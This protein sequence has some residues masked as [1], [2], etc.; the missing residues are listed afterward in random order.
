MADVTASI[1]HRLTRPEVRKRIDDFVA[2]FHQHYAN[3]GR[4][5]SRWS[6]DT[7]TFTLTAMAMTLPG[8]LDV[9]DQAVNLVVTLP[10]A[11]A[12]LAGGLK[13]QIEREGRKL[14]GSS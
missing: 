13:P 11:L 4:L 9:E 10:W 2:Q 5:E 1:P 7:M 8:H 12:M 3:L 6:G 14:L